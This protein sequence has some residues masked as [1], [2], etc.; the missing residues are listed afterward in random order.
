[1]IQV[2]QQGERCI[3]LQIHDEIHNEIR[4]EITLEFHIEISI[5]SIYNFIGTL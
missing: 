1:M 5:Q 4:V 2:M 3:V